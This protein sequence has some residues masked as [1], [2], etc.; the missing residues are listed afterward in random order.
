M[1]GEVH[2]S[3][4]DIIRIACGDGFALTERIDTMFDS[5]GA[6]IAAVRLMGR[7]DIRDGKVALHRDYFDPTGHRLRGDP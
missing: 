1:S 3:E 7:I 2:R 4:I 6:V 5:T